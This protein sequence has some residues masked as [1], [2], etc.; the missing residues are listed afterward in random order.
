VIQT[1][2]T[3]YLLTALEGQYKGIWHLSVRSYRSTLGQTPGFQIPSERTMCALTMGEN[4]FVLLEDPLAPTRGDVLAAAPPGQ[5]SAYLQGPSHYR[6]TFLT[7]RPPGA[8]EQ[9]LAQLKARWVS[10]RQSAASGTQRGQSSGQQLTIDG[11]IFAI[12]SD[13]LVRVGNVVLAG[14]AVKGMLLEVRAHVRFMM[15]S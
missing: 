9:L 14:G 3:V 6:T 15:L 10:V 12:G 7:I 13:W 2:I 8:L 4:V 11:Y 1:Y 5:E